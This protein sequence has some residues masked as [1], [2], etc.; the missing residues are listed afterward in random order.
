MLILTFKEK[1]QAHSEFVIFMVM[2]TTVLASRYFVYLP[3]LPSDSLGLIFILT[4]T[5]SQMS[6]LVAI[7]GLLTLP[8]LYL[9]TLLRR[10][11]LSGISA[12]FVSLLIIDTLVFAQYRFHINAIVVE[13]LLSGQ[14]ISFPWSMWLII[15]AGV[16]LLWASAWFFIRWRENAPLVNKSLCRYFWA[17]MIGALLLT[18]LIHIWAAA[19]AYQSV[20]Q[21]KRYLPL[22]YPATANSLMR[23]YGLIDETVIAQQKA[24]SLKTNNDLSYPLEPLDVAEISKPIN[25]L[26]VVIDSWRADTFNADNTPNLWQFAQNG[27]TFDHHIA[28]GNSTRAGIF[29]LFYGIPG[30]YWHSILANQQSPLLIDRLQQLNYQI[31][32]FTAAHLHKPEFDQTVFV[33]IQNLRSG[34]QGSRPAELDANLVKDWFAWYTKQSSNIPKF[35]FL[36]FDSPHGYDFPDNY[37]RRYQPMLD[38]I[39]YL[40]LHK[41]SDPIPFLNRYKTSVHYVDSLTKMVFQTLQETGDLDNTLVIIT[42]DHSQEINDNRLNFW[43]HNSNF[44]DAQVKV[45][46]AIIGPK[47][48][49]DITKNT[50]KFTSHQDIVPTL[51]EGY[52]GINNPTG[53]Y[54]T[55]ENLLKNI[56]AR[57]WVISASYSGYAIISHE[58]ILE[59]GASGQYDLLDK[60]NRQLKDK[61]ANLDYLQQA[62]EQLS[63]FSK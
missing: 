53:D 63:R 29:G 27:I 8:L 23:K 56:P 31:G 48:H 7:A 30:T 35:S 59:V 24:L 39:N 20:T 51:M 21:I 49:G 13:L 9:P 28:A 18:Q 58:S 40:K 17:L 42:G 60:T 44:T 54:A 16:G 6:L 34:S 11:L 52:L 2:I 45:P 47:L 32:I 33:N 5:F 62:L 14:V 36:F 46:F 41:D 50:Y 12:L 38:E 43:G 22:F 4:S 57:P 61:N 25:I 10:C 15:G 55:G 1:R 37:A 26:L 3:Q 19:N